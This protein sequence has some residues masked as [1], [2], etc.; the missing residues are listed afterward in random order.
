MK[1]QMPLAGIVGVVV[2]AST[3]MAARQASFEFA[4]ATIK[5]NVAGDHR[6]AIQIAPGGR[7]NVTAATLK[8]L[9][10][11]AYRVE[12]FQVIGGPAWVSSDRWDVQAIADENVPQSQTNKMLQTLLAERFQIKFH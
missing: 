1:V 3:I 4:A 5:P 10:R 6:S 11:T 12:E 8:D 2:A 7:L 9:I